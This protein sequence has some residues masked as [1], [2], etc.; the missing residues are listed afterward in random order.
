MIAGVAFGAAALVALVA[1]VVFLPDRK[2]RKV[3]FRYWVMQSDEGYLWCV[4]KPERYDGDW[5]YH[6]RA[7]GT[8]ESREQ[9]H[10]DSMAAIAKLRERERWE[11]EREMVEVK[12]A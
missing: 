3:D 6:L 7:N 9:A 4:E 8:S 1:L 12:K 10:D 2:Q 5:T 11:R